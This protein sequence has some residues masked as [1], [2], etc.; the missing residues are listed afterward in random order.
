MMKT[1]V[2]D[3]RMLIAQRQKKLSFYMQCLGEEAIAVAHGMALQPGRHVLS[4]LPPAG[5]ADVPRRRGR[6]WR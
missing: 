2:F 3:A 6:W 1:R 5:P 4:H